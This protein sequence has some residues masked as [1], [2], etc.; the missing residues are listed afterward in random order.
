MK[1]KAGKP[2]NTLYRNTNICGKT[3]KE[4]LVIVTTKFKMMV[5]SGGREGGGV[6][7]FK[8]KGHPLFWCVVITSLY[9]T[10]IF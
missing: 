3:I 4:K 1:S 6:G 2:S 9:L 8:I 5:T 10:C 7:N